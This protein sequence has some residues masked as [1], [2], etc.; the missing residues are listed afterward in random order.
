MGYSLIFSSI[1]KTIADTQKDQRTS[2]LKATRAKE[3][4]LVSKCTSGVN[5]A[6]HLI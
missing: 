4:V 1:C 6:V 5:N 2:S 3:V